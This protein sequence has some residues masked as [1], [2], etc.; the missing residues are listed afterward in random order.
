MT[1]YS[2]INGTHSEPQPQPSSVIQEPPLKPVL[3]NGH[4]HSSETPTVV[5]KQPQPDS[6]QQKAPA[7]PSTAALPN[8]APSAEI[9]SS[10]S[11]ATDAPPITNER[12]RSK[13][14]EIS[15]EAGAAVSGEDPREAETGNDENRSDSHSTGVEQSHS[16]TKVSAG[17]HSHSSEGVASLLA[18]PSESN[19]H[20][21]IPDGVEQGKGGDNIEEGAEPMEVEGDGSKATST[22]KNTHQMDTNNKAMSKQEQEQQQQQTK[23]ENKT[24]DSVI[25]DPPSAKP[26]A[27]AVVGGGQEGKSLPGGPL[28]F[29]FNIADGG[30]TE[31]H[32][33]WAEEKTKGFRLSVWG[34][35]H[36]YWMLKGICTYPSLLSSFNPFLCVSVWP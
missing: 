12:G 30:F 17:S 29:M 33:L 1:Q 10:S 15:S 35:H 28:K 32:T 2:A 14:R 20:D 13:E 21:P 22:E 36:D 16:G 25:V 27:T 4:A 8:E 24:H 7:S 19:S 3:Q 26:P 34:R 6:T 31:L 9:T 23:K 18:A 5:A 11:T